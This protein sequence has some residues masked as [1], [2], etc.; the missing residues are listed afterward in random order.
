MADLTL[1]LDIRDSDDAVIIDP[2]I[3]LRLSSASDTSPLK[4]TYSLDGAPK[5]VTIVDAPAA[6]PLMMRLTPSRYRDVASTARVTNGRLVPLAKVLKA[7]RLPSEWLPAFRNWA[8]VS[9][10]FTG[11]T[12]LLDASPAFQ[13]GEGTTAG[14][15]VRDV[16]D[17]ILP[18]DRVSARAKMALLN[19]CSRIGVESTPGSSQSWLTHLGELFWG[20]HER[21]IGRVSQD[22]AD[23]VRALRD[24]PPD[25]YEPAGAALH[26][27]NFKKVLGV[28]RVG[29]MFSVKT[30]EAQANLQFTVGLVERGGQTTWMMDVDIDEHGTLLG[31]A[32]DLLVHLRTKG[33]DPIDIHEVLRDKFTGC[34]L[35]YDLIPRAPIGTV[36]VRVVGASS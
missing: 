19:I 21:I 20:N 24:N 8:E 16:Y 4:W 25:G 33:T 12:T 6:N 11:M 30:S 23:L 7:P 22:C 36:E 10:T 2:S 1:S 9:S 3:D 31:H 28:T 29:E 17:G 32:F 5:L 34:N 18:T 14:R 27:R 26:K 15:I 13:L 35:G